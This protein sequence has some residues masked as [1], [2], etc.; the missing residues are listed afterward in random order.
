MCRK[1]SGDAGGTHGSDC[2]LKGF[3][4]IVYSWESMLI[5][6]PTVAEPDL[7]FVA[8]FWRNIRITD[9]LS[10]T[11]GWVLLVTHEVGH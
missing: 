2:V 4:C 10:V 7:L 9:F 8:L 3:K 5:K 11:T 6:I 1:N